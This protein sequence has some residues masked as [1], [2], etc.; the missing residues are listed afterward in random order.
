MFHGKIVF[1]EYGARRFSGWTGP[2]FEFHRA[3]AGAAST[4]E[5]GGEL[6][7]VKFDVGRRFVLWPLINGQHIDVFRQVEDLV[8]AFL[9]EAKLQRKACAVAPGAVLPYLCLHAVVFRRISGKR[10]KKLV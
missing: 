5:I 6:L 1:L 8:P 10:G 3:F 4:G 2:Q 7:L 9:V